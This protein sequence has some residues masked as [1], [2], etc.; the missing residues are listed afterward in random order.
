MFWRFG[1]ITQRDLIRADLD[2]F[3][4][5][6]GPFHFALKMLRYEEEGVIGLLGA[7]VRFFGEVQKV[8]NSPPP[9]LKGAFES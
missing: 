8:A 7:P 5:L 9:N 3:A 4:R 6:N 2:A 1:I